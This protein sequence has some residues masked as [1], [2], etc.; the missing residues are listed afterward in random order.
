[1]LTRDEDTATLGS[2]SMALLR[3]TKWEIYSTRL[4]FNFSNQDM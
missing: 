3:I 1:M 2:V 4:E